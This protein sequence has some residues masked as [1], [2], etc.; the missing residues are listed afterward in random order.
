MTMYS[1]LK[2]VEI[3]KKLTAFINHTLTDCQA[4]FDRND[5]NLTRN[6]SFGR[7]LR[8]VDEKN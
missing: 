5:T 4:D 6:Y 2:I 1:R 3:V 7:V 8:R